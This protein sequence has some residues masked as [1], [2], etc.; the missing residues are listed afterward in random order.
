MKKILV[1]F[2]AISILTGCVPTPE[3]EVV[4]NKAEGR[5]EAAITE[6][7]PVPAY[8]TEQI[9]VQPNGTEQ[10]AS[11]KNDPQPVEELTGTLQSSL[12]APKH[13]IDCAESKVYGGILQIE[14]D[15]DIEIPNVSKVPVFSVQTKTFSPEEK[16]KIAKVLLGEGPYYERNRERTKKERLKASIDS[17]SLILSEIDDRAYGEDY[18]YDEM[19]AANEAELQKCLERYAE[20]PDPGPMEPWMGSFQDDEICLANGENYWVNIQKGQ[21]SYYDPLLSDWS[22]ILFC[23]PSNNREDTLAIETAGVMFRDLTTE[24]FIP[25]GI[26][27]NQEMLG[28]ERMNDE[29]QYL[30]E[31]TRTYA[32]I[33]CYAY[34]TDHGS[35][36]AMQSAGVDM[37]S[38]QMFPESIEIN[39]RDGKVISVNWSNAIEVIKV[40][41]ENVTLLPFS[42]ILN[43]FKKQVFR[44]FYLD[45]EPGE[46][47]NITTTMK[48]TRICFSYMR[49]KKQDGD[50]KA[51]LLPVWD[52]MC[53]VNA[54][55][56]PNGVYDSSEE[57][58]WLPQQSILTINA[59]DG[60][61]I[62][63]NAG[64]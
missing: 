2:I 35:D 40:E 43:Y 11:E 49:V 5:L 46:D 62:D 23:I 21:I 31:L 18:P 54:S 61:I 60:S 53:A 52:F 7:T 44:T 10:N 33:P 25:Y 55:A 39:V 17:L 64:Y 27:R 3:S 6:A 32:G 9:E 38:E 8:V 47:Q 51:Y 12:G 4:L 63:R 57:K 56:F 41:N 59:I 37:Y 29:K 45:P 36:T 28:P 34:T 58:V 13:C 26:L 14:I 42:E 19:R 48:I 24:P 50:G 15:A 30:V 1:L 22:A 20:M 16:E